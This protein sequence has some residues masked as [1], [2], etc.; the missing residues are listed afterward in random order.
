M[1]SQSAN[2]YNLFFN[3]I[4]KKWSQQGKNVVSFPIA[5]HWQARN[6]YSCEETLRKFILQYKG[7]LKIKILSGVFGRKSNKNLNC[8]FWKQAPAS[9]L[10]VTLGPCGRNPAACFLLGGVLTHISVR[11]Q[12]WGWVGCEA[13][14]SRC[15]PCYSRSRD[16]NGQRVEKHSL[17]VRPRPWTLPPRL[18]ETTRHDEIRVLKERNPFTHCARKQHMIRLICKEMDLVLKESKRRGRRSRISKGSTFESN[19]TES[20]STFSLAATVHLWILPSFALRLA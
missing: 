1:T 15:I 14:V 8:V 18:S 16:G 3:S 13:T 19:Y 10:H 11:K 6:T 20:T 4:Q 17:H 5:V 9:Y 2:L 7:L 12:W